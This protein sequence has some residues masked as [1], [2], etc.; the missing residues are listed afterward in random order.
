MVP[1]RALFSTRVLFPART[2]A[3][4][5]LLTLLVLVGCNSRPARVNP[6]AINPKEAAQKAMAEYDTNG[7]GTIDGAE[8]DKAASLKSSLKELDTNGDGKIS[9]D[10]IASRIEQWQASKVGLMSFSCKVNLDKA[11]LAG[12][13][14]TLTPEK[15]L[16]TNL[17]PAT[18]TTNEQ[19]FAAISIAKDKLSNPNFSGVHVGFYRVEVSKQQNGAETIPA[20]YN[21]NT[22]L[23]QEVAQGVPALQSLVTF[24]VKSK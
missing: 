14:V 9:A 19:G 24:D 15:F 10:E 5:S 8:L 20:R 4:A 22:E 11:P 16:G 3:A 17:L 6:P 21:V 23:G 2:A 1:A 12:A 18:G 13:T 7:D